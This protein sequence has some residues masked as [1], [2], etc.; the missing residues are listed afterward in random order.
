MMAAC[1][2]TVFRQ[3]IEIAGRNASYISPQVQNDIIYSCN[4]VLQRSIILEVNEARFF[5]LLAD[6][7]TRFAKGAADSVP[8]IRSP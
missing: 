5:L 6:E 2:D 4:S 3:H 1:N 7:T 8:S